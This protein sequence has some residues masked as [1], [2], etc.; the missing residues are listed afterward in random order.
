[1]AKA[2]FN[3]NDLLN[4][5]SKGSSTSEAK[6]GAFRIVN[7][8]LD[9]LVPSSAN[10]YGIREVEELAAS[11]E[12]MGLLHNLVV[13]ELDGGRYE[14]IS[15]ERRYRACKLLY[16]GGNADYAA[17][18]CK[19]EGASSEAIA[20]LKLIF[21]NATARELTDFEKVEQAARMKELFRRL[22]AEGYE[23]KGRLREIVAGV[24]D[25]SPAQVG[26]LESVSE[27]LIPEYKEE[28]KA[29][30]IGIS[31]AYDASTLP[32]DKQRETLD[33]Y[34][35]EG[36]EAVK[37]A[38]RKT[39]K[40]QCIEEKQ[41]S[42]CPYGG[43]CK[44]AE[45][46]ASHVAKGGDIEGCAGCCKTCLAARDGTCNVVCDPVKVEQTAANAFHVPCSVIQEAE[47]AEQ[48]PGIADQEGTEADQAPAVAEQSAEETPS[49][50]QTMSREEHARMTKDEGN[51]QG[52][53]FKFDRSRA[54]QRTED[55]QRA[56]RQLRAVADNV[57]FDATCEADG[58]EINIKAACLRAA[59]LLE[60]I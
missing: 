34:K 42:D 1:M 18:P 40:Q 50:I 35:A 54:R 8:P 36:A 16:E 59:K 19:V 55:A 48:M 45:G 56:A 49:S 4:N 39:Y 53:G 2:K 7:I 24:L 43:K 14:I 5:Q 6:P 23:V 28:L 51:E 11:I 27:K 12:S 41:N 13:R 32:E 44:N 52:F 46:I 9:T 21:A 10:L 26:R 31:A 30:N 15:G 57:P 60:V 38:K 33:T 17:L 22:R 58:E 20:E 3:I 29:G 37:K 25:V 47:E